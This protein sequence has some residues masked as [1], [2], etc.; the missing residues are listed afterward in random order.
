MPAA[1]REAF[2]CSGAGDT[3]GAVFTL[4]LASGVPVRHCAELAN[5]GAG[6]VVQRVGAATLTLA[7]LAAAAGVPPVDGVLPSAAAEARA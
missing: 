6:V 1:I 7:E 4:G 5:C 2:G 3:V